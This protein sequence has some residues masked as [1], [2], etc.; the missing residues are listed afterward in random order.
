MSASAGLVCYD[1][2]NRSLHVMGY[3]A[4]A[5]ATPALLVQLDR[6]HGWDV[7]RFDETQR[8]YVLDAHL[9]IGWNDGSETC[10]EIAGVTGSDCTLAVRG[11][12]IVYPCHIPGV[13]RELPPRASPAGRSRL[14]LGRA[15]DPAAAGALLIESSTNAAHTLYVGFMPN[16]DATPVLTGPGAEIQAYYSLISAAHP[17]PE[18]ALGISGRRGPGTPGVRLGA[19]PVLLNSRLAWAEGYYLTSLDKSARVEHTTFEHGQAGLY[20]GWCVN[21]VLGC[22]FRNLHSAVRDG[23]SI[24]LTLT[25]CV[26][27]NNRHNWVLTHTARGLTLID[28]QW[29]APAEGDVVQPWDNPGTGRRQYPS[30]ISRRHIVVAVVDQEGRP[31]PDAMVAVEHE[32]G[33]QAAAEPP[34]LRVGA[35]GRTPGRGEKGALLMTEFITRATDDAQAPDHR[36][37]AYKIMVSAAGYHP[38]AVS[39]YQP[40]KS[41]DEVQIQMKRTSAGKD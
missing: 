39:G 9:V 1:R 7:I 11:N 21:P 24:V 33:D 38:A 25:D 22:V 16:K 3:P 27:E 17:A 5:P 35:A 12:V 6:L 15:D 34:R 2:D 20:N 8:R 37:Y 29:T 40:E 30:V 19:S 4:A 13:N 41:W 14:T 36:R 32:E 10:F 26:F 18:G 23:G 31:V 28:C